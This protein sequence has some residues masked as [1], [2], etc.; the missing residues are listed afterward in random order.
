MSGPILLDICTLYPNPMRLR[1]D[2]YRP[3]VW[4]LEQIATALLSFPCFHLSLSAGSATIRR[5]RTGGAGTYGTGCVL[6]PRRPLQ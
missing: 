6:D 3:A 1:D 5:G 2:M 4:H